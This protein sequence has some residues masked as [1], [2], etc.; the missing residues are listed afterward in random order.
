MNPTSALCALMIV[1]TNHFTMAQ[2]YE[3]QPFDVIDQFEEA[4]LRYYPPVMKIQ[5]NGDFGSLFRYISGNNENGQKIAMTTPVQMGNT[6]GEGVMQ[7]VLPKSFDAENTPKASGDQ[8]QVIQSEPGHYLA[9]Q[10]GGYTMDWRE[11]KAS[12]R[13]QEIAKKHGLQISGSSI[14]MVYN[15]PYQVFNR[16]NEVLFKV[17]IK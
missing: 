16:K 17:D 12:K 10:Y 4:E 7:F 14:I 5:S 6:Q 9:I 3:T 2:K 1:L 13:L 11:R 15:S 8:V